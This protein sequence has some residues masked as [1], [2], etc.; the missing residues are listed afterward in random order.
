MPISKEYA[1]I[2][3]ELK[4]RMYSLQSDLNTFIEEASEE[5]ESCSEKFQ[6]S[7]KGVSYSAWLEE[8]ESLCDTIENLSVE[9]D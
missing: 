9:P 3:E 6:E 8:I 7:E 2:P 1:K 4:L 5:F